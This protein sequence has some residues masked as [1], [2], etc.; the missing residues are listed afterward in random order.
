MQIIC[1]GEPV[2]SDHR[3]SIRCPGLPQKTLHLRRGFTGRRTL[4]KELAKPLGGLTFEFWIDQLNEPTDLGHHGGPLWCA[5][6]WHPKTPLKTMVE[7]LI[8]GRQKAQGGKV[9]YKGCSTAE[10]LWTAIVAHF[11]GDVR[12]QGYRQC[13]LM[14]T[15][16]QDIFSE[17]AEQLQP[18]PEATLLPAG[19]CDFF[20]LNPHGGRYRKVL[21][22]TGGDLL[23]VL[24]SVSPEEP[25][26]LL[27]AIVAR[28]SFRASLAPQQIFGGSLPWNRMAF[29]E[30]PF[31]NATS[32]RFTMSCRRTS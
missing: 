12:L 5:R 24:R 6:R 13:G 1:I 23:R 4:G 19:R 15:A 16:V 21:A 3:W 14:H 20:G 26:R 17:K 30:T 7:T 25:E 11:D 27:A 31:V 32:F 22:D 10:R 9:S 29:L 28:P 2:P 18:E 8:V